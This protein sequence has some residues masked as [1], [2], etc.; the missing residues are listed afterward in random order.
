MALQAYLLGDIQQVAI[1]GWL[2]IVSW[3]LHIFPEF[4]MVN[5]V[6]GF[7]RFA[8]LPTGQRM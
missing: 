8:S 2:M 4:H 1:M 7:T 6:T 3:L 5:R